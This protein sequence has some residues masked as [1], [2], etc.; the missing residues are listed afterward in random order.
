MQIEVQRGCLVE[1]AVAMNCL[2]VKL[3]TR[4]QTQQGHF[5]QKISKKELFE[6]LNQA[7]SVLREEIW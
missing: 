3:I 7:V 2:Q 6:A 5:L 1:S 4:G